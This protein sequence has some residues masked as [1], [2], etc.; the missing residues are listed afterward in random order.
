[1]ET[2]IEDIVRNDPTRAVEL[3]TFLYGALVNIC[4]AEGNEEEMFAT[5]DRALEEAD[6]DYSEF[7]LAEAVMDLMTAGYADLSE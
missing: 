7:H 3:L 2:T 6:E 4:E 1:M 5:A